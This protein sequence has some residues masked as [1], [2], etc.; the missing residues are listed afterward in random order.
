MKLS[1]WLAV[2]VTG[3][4]A[5]QDFVRGYPGDDSLKAIGMLVWVVACAVIW[6]GIIAL[7]L[8]R[9]SAW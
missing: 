3:T 5:E 4:S 8:W 9:A 2:N 7:C 1:S 6:G